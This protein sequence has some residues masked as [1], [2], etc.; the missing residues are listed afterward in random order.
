MDPTPWASLDD[1]QLLEWKIRALRLD[2]ERSVVEPFVHQLH[3]ELAARGLNFAPACHIGD[4]WFVPQGVPIIFIPFFLVHDRL[5]ELERRMMLEVEG[6]TPEWF[7]QL[8][9]HE[10]GHAISYAFHLQR[11]RRWRETFGP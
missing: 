6:E 5:R 10:A 11:K 9:R 4:E 3:A 2:L 8:M 1:A 7:M